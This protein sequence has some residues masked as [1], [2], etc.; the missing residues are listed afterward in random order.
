MIASVHNSFVLVISVMSV[1]K[2]YIGIGTTIGEPWP[3]G[4]VPI[5]GNAIGKFEG[6]NVGVGEVT[7]LSVK[8]V[9]PKVALRANG[10]GTL[11]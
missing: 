1:L 4:G 9:L 3:V 7:V 8:I 6:P 5:F 2:G 10:V 11:E